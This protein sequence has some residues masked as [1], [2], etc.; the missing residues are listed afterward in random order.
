MPESPWWRL[1]RDHDCLPVAIVLNMPESL[2]LARNQGR[3]DRSFGARV[4]R[5]QAEQLRRSLRGLR[6][7]G[8]RHIFVLN[9]PEEVEEASIE[10]TPLWTNL[11]HEHGPFRHHR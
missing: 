1:A 11:Q 4:V 2:C 9:S 8:F 6:R 10:R 3:P 7:E 5:R